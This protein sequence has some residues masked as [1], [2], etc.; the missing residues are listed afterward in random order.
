VNVSSCNKKTKKDDLIKLINYVSDSKDLTITK[1]SLHYDLNNSY[2]DM[3]N[4]GT[5]SK[6]II[7]FNEVLKDEEVEE[8]K[9]V[10]IR[11]KLE[12]LNLK[13]IKETNSLKTKLKEEGELNLDSFRKLDI[14]EMFVSFSDSE[15]TKIFIQTFNYFKV[16]TQFKLI[17][18]IKTISNLNP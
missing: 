8:K 11:K 6:H 1:I 4:L 7:E 13:E 5:T 12:K 16:R 10:K 2:Y 14:E 9:K 18:R 17:L 15:S 3:M